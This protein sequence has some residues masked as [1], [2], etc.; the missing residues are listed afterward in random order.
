MI[1]GY[2]LCGIRPQQYTIGLSQ[3]V[4]EVWLLERGLTKLP[5]MGKVNHVM[6]VSITNVLA[7]YC[8]NLNL[9]FFKLFIKSFLIC[10]SSVNPKTQLEGHMHRQLIASL[11]SGR[12]FD[13]LSFSPFWRDRGL[14]YIPSYKIGGVSVVGFEF[15]MKAVQWDKVHTF[16][17][18][19]K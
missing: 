17:S 2:H 13:M 10:I 6:R 16:I 19:Q 5:C 4:T 8:I 11:L 15:Q 12:G 18:V 14:L 9:V 7:R 3:R 1:S